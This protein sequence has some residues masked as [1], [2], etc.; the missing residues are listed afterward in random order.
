MSE[1]LKGK[2]VRTLVVEHLE[3]VTHNPYASAMLTQEEQQH[4]RAVITN[5]FK[6]PCE[7]PQPRKKKK[8]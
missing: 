7:E 3:A 1:K 6:E 5:F 4:S 8:G 2:G